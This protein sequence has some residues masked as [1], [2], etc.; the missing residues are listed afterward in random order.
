MGVSFFLRPIEKDDCDI[1]FR[2]RNNETVRKASLNSDIIDYHSHLE[3]F[4]KQI[5]GEGRNNYILCV[6]NEP[7]GVVYFI[8]DQRNCVGEFGFYKNPENDK[9]KIG[10]LLE[11]SALDQAF[12]ELNLR[13]LTC[14][15]LSN[16][17][18]ILP[19]HKWFGFEIEGCQKKQIKREDVYLDLFFLG[20]FAE[21]WFS[22]RSQVH[23][24]IE[25]S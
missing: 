10:I 5:A 18:R 4:D 15:V 2:W 22:N 11:I 3:W 1:L 13:K 16:N 17:K 23:A 19:F 6:E 8:V 14:V 9:L 12:Y 25:K 21:N 24:I 20:I 7:S